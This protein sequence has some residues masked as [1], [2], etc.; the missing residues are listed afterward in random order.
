MVA[1]ISSITL[2]ELQTYVKRQFG[3]ESGVQIDDSDIIRWV[4]MAT[5][6]ICAKNSVL[7]ATA[8]T[9]GVID[10]RSYD[11]GTLLAQAIKIEDVSYGSRTLEPTDKSGIRKLFGTEQ[12]SSGTPVYWYTWANQIMLW[13]VPNTAETLSIDFIQRPAD[14]S[15]AGDLLPLPDIY[16]EVIC[17]YVMSKAAEL[18]EDQSKST[19]MRRLAED[20]LTE[21]TDIGNTM[22][23]SFPVV[24]DDFEGGYYYPLY[25]G[26]V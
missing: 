14:V 8:S 3:D 24:R 10:Q 1:P 26:V 2:G 19:S 13:P 22:A 9:D 15:G 4:N 12:D 18:D 21:M 17:N 25:G 5:V 23:G 6:D 20:K 16:Y 11:V 7:Q